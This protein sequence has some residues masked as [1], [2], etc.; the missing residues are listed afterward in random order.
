MDQQRITKCYLNNACNYMFQIIFT[1]WK[2]QWQKNDLP[3]YD[4]G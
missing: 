1:S 2:E 4:L 3:L